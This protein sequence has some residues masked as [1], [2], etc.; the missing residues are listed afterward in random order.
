MW[1]YKLEMFETMLVI[2]ETISEC[3]L[4]IYI[5]STVTPKMPQN[6]AEKASLYLYF[7]IGNP[8]EVI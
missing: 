7:R 4:G 1:I 8:I 2:V 6:A 3:Q 5:Y